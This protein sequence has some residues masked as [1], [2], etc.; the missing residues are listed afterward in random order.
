MIVA[1]PSKGRAGAVSS[2]KLLGS[3][4]GLAR[5]FVPEDEAD[6][7]RSGNGVPVEGVPLA[8][9]GI[10]A[11]RNFILEW[12]EKQG[13]TELVMVDD[14]GVGWG[15]FE[16]GIKTPGLPYPDAWKLDLLTNCFGMAREAGTNLFGFS[17]SFDKRFYREYSPFSLVCV[18]VGNLM[19]IVIGD[20]QRFDERLKLKEDYD[21]SLQSL[22]RYRRVLRS[23]KHYWH[24]E[25]HD[26]PGGCRSYRTFAAEKESIDLLQRKWGKGIVR[27]NSR[28]DWEIMVHCPIPG[29]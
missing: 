8:V 7:Y 9:K 10:T 19:G 2:I 27:R 13:E 23:N 1:V 11:T 29:I 20:G 17:V 26:T 22:R 21:F 16:D 28:K 18:V 5:L 14:D 24:V 3:A 4:G 6:E 25:H 15:Y 12:C